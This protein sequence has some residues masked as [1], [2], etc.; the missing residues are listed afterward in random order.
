MTARTPWEVLARLVRHS[1]PRQSVRAE[2]EVADDDARLVDRDEH[3]HA[4]AFRLT[5]RDAYVFR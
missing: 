4:F 5:S 3:E 2:R 1:T